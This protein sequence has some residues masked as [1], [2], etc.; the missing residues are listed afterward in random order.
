[1]EANELDALRRQLEEREEELR[2][3]RLSL[4]VLAP[5]DLATGLLNRN[6]LL[7]AIENAARWMER[8]REQFGVVAIVVPG[9][10]DLRDNEARASA[11]RHL[12]ASLAAAVRGVDEVGR[13]NDSTFAMV[14]RELSRTGVDAVAE[15]LKRVVSVAMSAEPAPSNCQIGAVLV[16][17]D[18]RQPS[19]LLGEAYDAAVTATSGTAHTLVF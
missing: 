11:V 3:L 7:E 2:N 15:R 1:M 19:T 4:D 18:A 16:V 17:N 12:A 14:L 8:R 6:G 9:V 5:V 13:L 10:E